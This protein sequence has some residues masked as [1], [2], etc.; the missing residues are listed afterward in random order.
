M[1][2]TAWDGMDGSLLSS[3]DANAQGFFFILKPK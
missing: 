3:G 1:V 2:L